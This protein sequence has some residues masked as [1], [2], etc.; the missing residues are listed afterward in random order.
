M[1]MGESLHSV[2]MHCY[3]HHCSPEPVLLKL[4]ELYSAVFRDMK[5]TE[6]QND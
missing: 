2:C 1:A 4:E 5:Y 3:V 6:S